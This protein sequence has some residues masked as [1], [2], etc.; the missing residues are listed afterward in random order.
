MSL[1]INCKIDKTVK[2]AG[3]SVAIKEMNNLYRDR[4]DFGQWEH[5]ALAINIDTT[6]P[7]PLRQETLLHEVIHAINDIYGLDFKHEQVNLLSVALHQV[8]TDNRG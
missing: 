7:D 3:Y 4:G 5:P 2:I 6:L 1:D 8:F